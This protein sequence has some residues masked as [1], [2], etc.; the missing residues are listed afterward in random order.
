[1]PDWVKLTA[2][3]RA[4]GFQEH[5]LAAVKIGAAHLSPAEAKAVIAEIDKLRKAIEFRQLHLFE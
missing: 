2:L 4:A 1:M 3:S 5:K